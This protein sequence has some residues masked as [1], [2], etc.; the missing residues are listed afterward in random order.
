[1]NL[2]QVTVPS[3]NVKKAVEFYQQLGLKLIV[4]NYPSYA[5][6]ECPEGLS[7]VSMSYGLKGYLHRKKIS[8]S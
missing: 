2:N 5:R 1:M 8:V 3:L 7:T 4:E 6:F